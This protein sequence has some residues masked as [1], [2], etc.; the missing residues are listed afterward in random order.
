[1][2]FAAAGGYLAAG[3]DLA[4]AE[5]DDEGVPGAKGCAG[6]FGEGPEV[7]LARNSDANE[8]ISQKSGGG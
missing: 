5:V 6:V 3:M 1:M 4:V 8:D 2:K 7:R